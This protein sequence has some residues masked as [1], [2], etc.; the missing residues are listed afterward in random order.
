[1]PSKRALE[2]QT[3]F[4]M[5]GGLMWG[6][7]VAASVSPGNYQILNCLKLLKLI[8]SLPFSPILKR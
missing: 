3:C 8:P 6:D 1:M 4:R 5:F 2:I 7:H